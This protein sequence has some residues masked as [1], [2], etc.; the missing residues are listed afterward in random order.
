M[1]SPAL[2]PNTTAGRAAEQIFSVHH[3]RLRE[4]DDVS[5][6][7]ELSDDEQ[8]RIAAVTARTGQPAAEFVHEAIVSHLDEV[9]D[10]AWAEESAAEWVGSEQTTRPLGEL[11]RELGL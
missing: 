8:Q 4:G 10:A 1:P 9:D 6:S 11:R 7:I 2:T 3:L 5:L